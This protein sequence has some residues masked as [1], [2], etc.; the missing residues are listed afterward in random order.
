MLQ[1]TSFIESSILTVINHIDIVSRHLTHDQF[2]PYCFAKY[3]LVNIHPVIS[4]FNTLSLLSLILIKSFLFSA[5][6]LTL[7]KA[8][9]ELNEV[10]EPPLLIGCCKL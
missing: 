1:K 4:T 9:S 7:G 8:S 6:K 5:D 10:A 3:K 2:Y